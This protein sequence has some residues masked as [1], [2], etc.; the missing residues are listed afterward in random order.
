MSIFSVLWNRE[1]HNPRSIFDAMLYTSDL[2]LMTYS[3][4]SLCNCELCLLAFTWHEFVHFSKLPPATRILKL[5]KFIY[6]YL[7]FYFKSIFPISHLGWPWLTFWFP[8]FVKY[9]FLNSTFQSVLLGS[10]PPMIHQGYPHHPF[11][12][13]W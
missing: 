11:P 3:L 1:W 13:Y 5:F 9:A 7:Q 8:W 12:L 4:I 6:V 10:L 2:Q